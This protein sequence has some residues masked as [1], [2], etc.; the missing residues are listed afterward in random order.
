[1]LKGP[2]RSRHRAAPAQRKYPAY[3]R[4]AG[5]GGFT[6]TGFS[7]VILV[8]LLVLP[9]NFVESSLIGFV[10]TAFSSR[11]ALNKVQYAIDSEGFMCA[12]EALGRKI[13][14]GRAA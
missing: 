2:V 10:I 12:M 11:S 6:P 1:M 13:K 9:S 8:P 5:A 7:P 4:D 14:G 3:A